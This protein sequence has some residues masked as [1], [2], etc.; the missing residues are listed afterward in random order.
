MNKPYFISFIE[1]AI[2]GP[3]YG[4]YVAGRIEVYIEPEPHDIEEIRFFT[5]K[6]DEYFGFRNKWDFKDVSQAELDE[7]RKTAIEDFYEET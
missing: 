5:K 4:N 1:E 6:L 3:K 7:I 2:M